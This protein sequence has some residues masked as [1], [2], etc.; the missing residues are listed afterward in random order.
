MAF[1]F[2]MIV[3]YIH[4]RT[5]LKYIFNVVTLLVINLINSKLMVYEK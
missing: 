3:T 2:G 1:Y 5:E 4:I